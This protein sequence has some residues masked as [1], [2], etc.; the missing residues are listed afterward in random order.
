MLGFEWVAGQGCVT[1]VEI[2]LAPEP[3]FFPFA[4]TEVVNPDRGWYYQWEIKSTSR[5]PTVRASEALR[6]HRA[7]YA[8]VLYMM[9]LDPVTAP[10]VDGILEDL[11]ALSAGGV[12]AIVR[13]A[14]SDSAEAD[15][16]E[17]APAVV[18]ALRT[19]LIFSFQSNE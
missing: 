10:P 18:V 14:Y 5:F 16:V 3:V 9:Y 2:R 8:L 15:P 13:F 12:K 7:G 1:V 11:A 4:T 19:G 17:P 6:L